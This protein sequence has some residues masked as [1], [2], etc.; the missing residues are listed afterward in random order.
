MES[1][2]PC[3]EARLVLPPLACNDPSGE[4]TSIS[5]WFNDCVIE[6]GRE[7]VREV[8]AS[9]RRVI[10]TAQLGDTHANAPV[11]RKYPR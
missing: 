7:S 3:R 9:Y 2:R 11:L 10:G 4:Q 1:H 5:N 6:H 8:V